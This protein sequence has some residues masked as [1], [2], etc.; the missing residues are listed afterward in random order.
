MRKKLTG[1][2]VGG[3]LALVCLLGVITVINA[4]SGDKYKRQILAQSQQYDSRKIPFKRGNITDRNG[5]VLASSVKVYNV[6]LDCLTVNSNDDYT[7]PTIQALQEYLDIDPEKV[8]KILNADETKESQ[9]QIIKRQISMED[10]KNFEKA[11]S[12]Q[13]KGISKEEI[14]RRNDIQGVWFEEDYKRIYPLNSLACDVIGFTFEGNT[15][16]WGIEG[17]YN[18]TLNGKAGRQ[19]GYAGGNSDVEQTIIKP[20]NGENIVTTLDAN[21]QQVVENYIA[22]M[23]KALADGPNGKR[24]AKNIGVIVAN[25]QNGEIL[26]MG[27]SDPYDLNNPRDLSG[28]FDQK[29]IKAMNDEQIL[30]ELYSMWKNLCITETYEPGSVVKPL[31][32]SAALEQGIISENSTYVCD[33]GEQVAEEFIRCAIYPDAHGTQTLGEVIQNSCNDAM[34]AIGRQM[35]AEAFLK[36]QEE[37]NFGMLT[38]IDLPGES[39]GILYTKET[40]NEVELATS[41]FGQG[42]NCTMIQEMA[43]ICAAINGGVYYQPHVAKQFQDENGKVIKNVEPV[44]LKEVISAETSAKIREYMSMSVESGTGQASKVQGYSMGGKTGTAEKQPRGNGKYLV[45]FVGFAPL[46]NPQV[47]I[48]VI[49]DEPNVEEQ[50]SSSYAQYIAQGV[51]SEILP[52]MNIFPDEQTEMETE[53]WEGFKGVKKLNDVSDE[54]D[55]N[56]PIIDGVSNPSPEPPENDSEPVIGNKED[57]DG[58]TNADAGLED[59]VPGD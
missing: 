28:I 56:A 5:T 43:A 11:I 17:Y 3:L 37:Y 45:S 49:I 19:Y 2:Y 18:N 40:M 23:D 13:E 38:G 55:P 51:L 27:S 58:I 31:V 4:K 30:K 33:G 20:V 26:A 46:D 14:A 48:Y 24:G 32:I 50:A 1:L 47:A 8:R 25:P 42:Y 35:H 44:I 16:D 12:T 52:Y 39:T 6:I 21:I 7:E 15:A 41:S 29:E 22:A 9:Y 34:M 57:T 53:L 36:H 54:E 59:E 10:K